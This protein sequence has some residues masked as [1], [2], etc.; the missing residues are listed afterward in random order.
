MILFIHTQH[1]SSHFTLPPAC[2]CAVGVWETWRRI[3]FSFLSLIPLL[4]PFL[5][6]FPSTAGGCLWPLIYEG[7]L[8]PGGLVWS[9]LREFGPVVKKASKDTSHLFQYLLFYSPGSGEDPACSS[10][11]QLLSAAVHFTF[12][13]SMF[14]DKCLQVPC[15]GWQKTNAAVVSELRKEC[16]YGIC[17]AINDS[18]PAAAKLFGVLM[19]CTKKECWEK[20]EG[21][22]VCIEEIP[23]H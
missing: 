2:L 23:T 22:S 10:I 12:C 6:F 3:L 15:G 14:G 5:L 18:L 8:N 4:P 1:L 21:V 11:C 16:S 20:W 17:A 13:T 7:L 19:P 9:T